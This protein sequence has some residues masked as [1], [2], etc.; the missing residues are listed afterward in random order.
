V[1]VAGLVA[2][3]RTGTYT[4]TRTARGTTS[5]GVVADGTQTT[6]TIDASVSPL[7]EHDQVNVP[8]GRRS[9]EMRLIFTTT[10]LRPSLQGGA[11]EADV[12]TIAGESWSIYDQ[13]AWI[14]PVSGAS[15]YRYLAM[16]V[17]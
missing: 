10:L 4:V 8:E 17:R 6:F 1:D 14:D 16:V 12:V 3:F 5:R 9:S 13:D 11:Y 15:F 7:G 2:S